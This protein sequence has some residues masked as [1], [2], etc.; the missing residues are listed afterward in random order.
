MAVSLGGDIV[1][2]RSVVIL[3]IKARNPLGIPKGRSKQS[4]KVKYRQGCAWPRLT[5]DESAR[6]GHI[7]AKGSNE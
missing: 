1:R 2:W 4:T 6:S 7:F 3:I 5:N